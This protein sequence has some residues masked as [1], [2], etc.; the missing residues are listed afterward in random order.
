[1]ASDEE[2][3]PAPPAD[4]AP[5]SEAPSRTHG[6]SSGHAGARWHALLSARHGVSLFSALF[7]L[8]LCALL[9]SLGGGW[10]EHLESRVGD[11]VWRSF[12][13]RSDERRLI[14]VDIDEKSLREVGPWPW[15]RRTQAELIERLAAAGVR[16]QVFDIVY[17]DVHPDDEAMAQAITAHRPILAQIF[18]IGAT[19]APRAGVP[20]GSLDWPLCPTLFP[21]A[22]GF[23]ANQAALVA[24]TEAVHGWVGHITPKVPPDGVIRHQ[25]AVVC[26][27]GKSYPALALAALMGA[28]GE[29]GLALQRGSAWLDAPWVLG[30]RNQALPAVPLDDAGNIR[31]PWHRHP[32]SFISLSAVDVLRGQAP[33]GVLKGAWALVGSS[34]FG[35]NDTIAT[36]FGGASAG[37][38]AH[39]QIVTGMIDGRIPYT[40]RAA[41]WL[42]A[43][44][45]IGA[46]I[47][48]A[49]LVRRPGLKS[50]AVRQGQVD[51]RFPPYLLIAVALACALVFACLHVWALIGAQMWIGWI[52]P[53]LVV[54]VIGAIM[55][56]L[57]HARSRM[58]RD[59]LYT[60]LSTYLPAPVAAALALQSPSGAIRASNETVSVL[61]ADIRNFSAYCE[62]RP[63][64]EAAAVLHAL[65]SAATRIV[66]RHG[67]VIEAF[68][69]D[70]V[71]AVWHNTGG[72]SA[73]ATPGEA[74]PAL[75]APQVADQARQ[76]LAAASDLYEASFDILPDPAPAGL[77]PLTLGIGI[78]SGPSMAGSF[79][80]ANRRTHMVLGRTVTIAS[81]L[82]DMTADLAHPILVGEGLAA[83]VGGAELESLG[84]FLLEG[85][86]VPHHVYACP[87]RRAPQLH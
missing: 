30:G 79:G 54:V 35:L 28:T 76:A 20:A 16:Q 8:V 73:S 64:E 14:V 62:A 74:A 41:P 21:Q 83:Q 80:P 55:G 3:A 29:S 51:S 72:A 77:E 75:Q 11:W 56:A 49:A 86:R 60:H 85:M 18:S 10:A 34:A 4:R 1:M 65:F 25:P 78:E 42:E 48:L 47:L 38:Q 15:P 71:I 63:P 82:V 84:T 7:G 23:L 2:G 5:A 66:E 87:T 67:G 44:F 70:A 59:R 39:A 45:A 50:L 81:R 27:D 32:A 22:D 46:L 12:A 57:D 68:Q 61:F 13:E 52:R 43:A 17:T 24:A 58:D 40:P 36:P 9:A 31:I 26:F 53:A 6:A 69:G 33:A 37:L 19:P